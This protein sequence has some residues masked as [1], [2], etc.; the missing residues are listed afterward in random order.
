MF[1]EI[2]NV[3]FFKCTSFVCMYLPVCFLFF[4]VC[5]CWVCFV[6]LCVCVC[7]C[8]GVCVCVFVKKVSDGAQLGFPDPRTL[9]N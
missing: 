2:I 1:G 4:F 9:D 7:L 5:V 3:F 8:C 6:C